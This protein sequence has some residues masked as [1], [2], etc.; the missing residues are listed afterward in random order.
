MCVRATP[1]SVVDL[2][3]SPPSWHGWMKLFFVTVNWI[4]SAMT[5]SISLPS[6]FKRTMGRNIFA[7]SYDGLLGLGIII[8]DEHLKQSGQCP[9]L[10][11]ALATLMMLVRHS[12]CLIMIFRCRHESLSGP[13][14]EDSNLLMIRWIIKQLKY[15]FMYSFTKKTYKRLFKTFLPSCP[16]YPIPTQKVVCWSVYCL[17]RASGVI[18][19]MPYYGAVSFKKAVIIIQPCSMLDW[20]NWLCQRHL[21]HLRLCYLW[22]VEIS[23]R[24]EPEQLFLLS[25]SQHH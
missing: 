2:N 8:V 20:D 24:G 16:S 11:H 21:R 25:F 13:G 6:V 1:A 19:E 5:F 18:K 22:A 14:A 15:T 9:K 12:S 17:L 3:F 10:I 4:L 7:W 23:N